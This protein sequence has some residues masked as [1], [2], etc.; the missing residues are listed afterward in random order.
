MSLSKFEM[1]SIN[2]VKLDRENPRIARFLEMYGD[3]ISSEQMALALGSGSSEGI[4]G[5]PSYN[6]LKQSIQTNKGIIHP[7]IVNRINDD[8]TVI[9]GNTRLLIYREF[10]K[11]D[12]EGEWDNIPS[13]VYSNLEKNN[14]DAIR[15]Q[16]HLVGTRNWDPYSKAKYLNHLRNSENLT[17]GQIVDFCGGKR[18]EIQN[19]IDAYHDMETYYRPLLDNDQDFDPTRFSSFVELQQ[20]RVISSILESGYDKKVFS[21]WV[22][23]HKLI[24]IPNIRQLPKILRN[25]QAKQIFLQHDSKKALEYLAGLNS[26]QDGAQTLQN[27]TLLQLMRALSAHINQE[28]KYSDIKRLKEQEDTEEV[29]YIF[30]AKDAITALCK[31]IKMEE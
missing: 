26:Q 10:L 21:E 28:L 11:D 22:D 2:Q 17:F 16:S 29:E 31:D 25:H 24:P 27:A 18:R 15:L 6:D 12:I 3:D 20:N 5:G 8:I 19:Y 7:I 4:E 13:M 30:E 23:K 14:I 9:E 1:L